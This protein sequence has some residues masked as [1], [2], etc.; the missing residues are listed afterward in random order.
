[1]AGKTFRVDY[2]VPMYHGI[3]FRRSSFSPKAWAEI[4]RRCRITQ[5]DAPSIVSIAIEC[6]DGGRVLEL[7]ATIEGPEEEIKK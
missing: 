3:I 5:Y 7:G 2:E 1:M 4:V 6:D